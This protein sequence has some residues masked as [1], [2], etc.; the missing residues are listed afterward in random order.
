MLTTSS[1]VFAALAFAGYCTALGLFIA[2]NRSGRYSVLS[3]AV[4]DYGVG[5]TK[6]L[7][8]KSGIA[9]IVAA[10]CLALA[11][12]LDGRFPVKGIW[13][14]VG[15]A[16]LRVGVIR[17]PT[18]LE[19]EALGRDGRLHYLFAIASF[20][21]LYMGIDALHPVVMTLLSGIP[22]MAMSLLRTVI[23]ISLIGVVVT[24]LPPLRRVFGLVERVFLLSTQLWLLGLSA[25]LALGG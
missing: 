11:L 21:L 20:A 17:F 19:G 9:G 23:T 1:H 22:A 13:F 5:P 3:H 25:L 18:S 10:A 16:V 8:A 7:F 6:P 15:M 2:L 24:M 12:W 14:L 4:S